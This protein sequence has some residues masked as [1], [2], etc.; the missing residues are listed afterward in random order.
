MERKEKV[1]E[2]FLEYKREKVRRYYFGED[3]EGD[4]KDIKKSIVQSYKQYLLNKLKN[5]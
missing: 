5:K 1:P 4:F 2:S 3:D